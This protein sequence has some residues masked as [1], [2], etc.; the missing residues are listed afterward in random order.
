MG[1][2]RRKLDEVECSVKDRL[3]KLGRE[4]EKEKMEEVVGWL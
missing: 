1:K 2:L 4:K 3:R